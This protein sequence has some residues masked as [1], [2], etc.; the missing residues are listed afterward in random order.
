M[1]TIA[2]DLMPLGATFNIIIMEHLESK[3]RT[4]LSF[5]EFAKAWALVTLI[6]TLICYSF[7]LLISL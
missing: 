2:G 7:L 3:Y 1:S 4:N 5:K 6:N